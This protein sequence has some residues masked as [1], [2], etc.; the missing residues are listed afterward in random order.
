MQSN[1]AGH[2]KRWW[3]TAGPA[4]L[5]A[6]AGVLAFSLW[7][8]SASAPHAR[9]YLDVSACLLTDPSGIGPGT[10]AAPVWAAMQSASLATHVMVT[11]LRDGGPADARP[12][13][14]T[15]IERHCGVIIA[16]G[17]AAP[18]V[19]AAGKANPN[20]AFLLVAAPSPARPT[21]TP[22]TVIVS[23]A[24]ARGRIGQMI[25]SLAA[26]APAAGS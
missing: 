17:S 16:T 24:H 18:D 20:Q 7:P 8:R 4:V 9:S 3:L 12:M 11:Y 22:N 6:A 23:A 2:G 19:I 13:L 10:P 26:D 25:R 15:L 1:A 14:N 21:G 5:I